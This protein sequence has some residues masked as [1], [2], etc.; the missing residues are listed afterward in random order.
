[1]ILPDVNLLLY[2]YDS[3][4][5]FHRASSEWLST[6]L[7]GPELVGLCGPVIFAF[8]RIGTSNRAFEHPFTIEE[9]CRHVAEWLEQP[10]AEFVEFQ[11]AD[12]YQA[13]ALLRQAGTGGNLTTDAQ[14]AALAL[15]LGAVVHSSDSDY[16]RFSNLRW[17]N[18]LND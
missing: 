16:A 3:S 13:L 7:Q 2:A 14:V 4:S 11:I 5:R 18:P 10:A 12:I 9:A 1:M 8:V 17:H 15:R 6:V